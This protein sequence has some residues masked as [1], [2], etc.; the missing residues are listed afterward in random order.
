MK[1]KKRIGAALTALALVSAMVPGAMAAGSNG[2]TQDKTATALNEAKNTTVSLEIGATEEHPVSDVVFVLDKSTSVDVKDAAENMLDE[3]MNRVNPDESTINVGVV[4]FNNNASNEGYCLELTELNDNS[5]AQVQEI[6]GK[7]LSSGTNIEAGIRAGMAM[8][9]GDTG[10][11]T[12]NKHLVLVTDGVTYLW[13][14]GAPKTT[15]SE[16]GN[17]IATGTD[18]L[19]TDYHYR[20]TNW[21]AYRNAKQWMSDNAAGIQADVA[22]YEV[23]CQFNGTSI[24]TNLRKDSG[25][26]FIPAGEDHP[27]TALEIATYKAGQAWEDAYEAGYQ[28]YAYADQKYTDQYPWGPNFIA[29]LYTIGGVSGPVPSDTTGMFDG[30]KNSILY[31]I[32]SGTVTDEIGEYFNWVGMDT[33]KL[34]VGGVEQTGTVDDNTMTFGENYSVTYNPD[35]ESF[36]WDINVPVETGKGLKLTYDLALDTALVESNPPANPAAVPTNESAKLDYESSDGED[37]DTLY[38][39]VPTVSLQDKT[40][41][42]VLEKWIVVNGEDVEQDDVAAGDEVNFKLTSNV[43]EKLTN[44]L[45]PDDVKPPVVE[46]NALSDLEGRGS[47]TLVFHDQMAEQ[48]GSMTDLAVTIDGVT[49]PATEDDGT[50]NYTYIADPAD[51]CTFE[52][53]MDLVDLYEK[54]YITDEDIASAAPIVVTYTATLDKDTTAGNYTNTAWVVANGEESSHDIVT[55]KTYQIKAYKF[56]QSDNTALAGAE[57][58]LV[59]PDGEEY[60]ATSDSNGFAIFDGLDAGVYTLTETKAP[61]GFVKSDTPITITIPSQA[62]QATN[63]ATVNFANSPIPHTGGMGTAMFTVGGAAILAAA[64]A[65]FVVSRRKDET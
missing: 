24:V 37:N 1:L 32:Q 5:Y 58:K 29:G 39:P 8:L 11:K 41:D 46:I 23:D 26:N 20:D 57:F 18:Y 13:G 64:G 43:P 38:F 65:L 53:T 9:A 10:T 28:L 35:T 22:E 60:T 49:L 42:S 14:T 15:F 54:G 52:I 50:A 27:Y 56:N 3:L 48:L 31:E 30:V 21:D 36:T 6:F 59:G 45:N 33:V 17:S 12:E 4:V 19:N 55:V 62:D 7:S 47:Y 40:S 16:L 34:T 2:V 51:D 63:I 61:E 44:Y 25:T